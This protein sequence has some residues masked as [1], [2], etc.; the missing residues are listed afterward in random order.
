MEKNIVLITGLVDK[1]LDELKIAGE[2]F[3]NTRQLLLGTI[4]VKLADQLLQHSIADDGLRSLAGNVHENTSLEEV[5]EMI[6]GQINQTNIDQQSILF[7]V[8]KTTMREFIEKTSSES[9]KLL[10]LV[11]QVLV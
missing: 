8:A 2:E 10:M 4:S 1:V 6:A 5:F 7:A 11:D 3:L 9:T